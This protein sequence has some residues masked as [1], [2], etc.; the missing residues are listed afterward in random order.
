MEKGE[1]VHMRVQRVCKEGRKGMP[2]RILLFSPFLCS[3]SECKNR[4]WSNLIK[5]QSTIKYLVPVG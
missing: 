2:A 1:F 4:D 3:D 5:C